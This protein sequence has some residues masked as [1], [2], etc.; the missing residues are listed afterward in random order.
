MEQGGVGQ[1]LR[2][3]LET[4]HD[5]IRPGQVVEIVFENPQSQ[6]AAEDTAFADP[7]TAV[8]RS[9]LIHQGQLTSVMLI[10]KDSASAHTATVQKRWIVTASSDTRAKPGEPSEPMV[11]VIQGLQP[12]ALVVLN[13]TPALADGQMVKLTVEPN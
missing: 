7:A 12:G 13:P 2:L 1:I 3:Q 5:T 6:E 10:V 8:P 9:A 11:K 4:A